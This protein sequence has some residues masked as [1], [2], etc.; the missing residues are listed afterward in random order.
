MCF[1]I[2]VCTKIFIYST[3][4]YTL[5]IHCLLMMRSLRKLPVRLQ[6]VSRD[7]K[8]VPL[9][10]KILTP[11]ANIREFA[12]AISLV[13]KIKGWDVPI[14]EV[15]YPDVDNDCQVTW[16]DNENSIR[17]NTISKTELFQPTITSDY[18][19]KNDDTFEKQHINKVLGKL[20]KSLNHGTGSKAIVLDHFS[21][22][23]SR[24]LS[25]L[26][27]ARDN[28]HVPNLDPAFN[29]ITQNV[30][31]VSQQTLFAYLNAFDVEKDSGKFNCF[32]DYC[33]TFE[34]NAMCQ[35][36][37][38]LHEI[39]RKS[40]LPRQ[41]G[42]LWLTFSTRGTPGGASAVGAVVEKWLQDEAL[43][44]AYTVSLA[45]HWSYGTV[46]TLIYVTGRECSTMDF[47]Y[48]EFINKE[49]T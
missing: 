12:L 28:I 39:F 48:L 5:T 24:M 32:L 10:R 1:K 40:V 49:S 18:Q 7:K 27:L 2:Q 22:K 29:E 33:C 47:S 21:L 19:K 41:R 31:I 35:P 6:S 44:F 9:K 13:T 17:V 43:Y 11:G 23:T 8:K 3:V 4:G 25:K 14:L 20:M 46:L 26:G 45:Y 38:D 34:G 42:V 37:L 36:T 16:L 15:S 30:A